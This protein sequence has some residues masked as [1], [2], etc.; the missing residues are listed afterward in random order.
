MIATRSG[1]NQHARQHV[2]LFGQHGR[3]Q[4]SIVDENCDVVSIISDA[5]ENARVRYACSTEALFE[6]ERVCV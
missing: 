3:R 2:E 1:T 5:A 4:L 6:R